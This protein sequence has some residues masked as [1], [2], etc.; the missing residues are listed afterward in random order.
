MQYRDSDLYTDKKPS[1]MG[2]FIER[3]IHCYRS[4]F[5]YEGRANRSEFWALIA[6]HLALF[7]VY[8][9]SFYQPAFSYQP[10]VVEMEVYNEAQYGLFVMREV[11]SQGGSLIPLSMGI[12]T[13]MYMAFLGLSLPALIA[14]H[15]RRLHDLGRPGWLMLGSIVPIY[16]LMFLVVFCKKGDPI[17][18]EWSVE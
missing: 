17:F 9:V 7:A 16:Y 2:A 15:I 18:N 6:F 4:S 13:L 8:I 12:D 5:V 3:I 10:G 11:G 1:L 14:V